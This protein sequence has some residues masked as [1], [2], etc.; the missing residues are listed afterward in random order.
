MTERATLFFGHQEKHLARKKFGDEVL[1]W[2]SVRSKVQMTNILSSQP[3]PGRD[4]Q[5]PWG[6]TSAIL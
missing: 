3:K 5:H 6:L 4:F 1:A 2:L